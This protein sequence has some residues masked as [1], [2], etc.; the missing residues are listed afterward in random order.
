[1]ADKYVQTCEVETG[2]APDSTNCVVG[3]MPVTYQYLLP[4]LTIAEGSQIAV[5][6]FAVWAVAFVFKQVARPLNQ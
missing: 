4:P 1:M 6:I 2:V 3:Y 5:A